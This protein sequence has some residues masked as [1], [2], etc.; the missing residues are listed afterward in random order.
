MLIPHY[1]SAT[2]FRLTGELHSQIEEA[3]V[4]KPRSFVKTQLAPFGSNTVLT[5]E[6]SWPIL[7]SL[8]ESIENQMATIIR[9]HSAFWWLHLYRRIGVY[10]S[11]KHE[12][13]TDSATLAI[14][15]TTVELA[16]FKYSNLDRSDDMQMSN[17]LRSKDVLGGL[18]R[19]T[20]KMAK[21][22]HREYLGLN[23]RRIKSSNQWVIRDFCQADFINMYRLEGLAYQ[24]WRI[25]AKLRAIG[26]GDV[27]QITE[28]GDIQTKPCPD[29]D[30][31]L[32]NYDNRLE[33]VG[34]DHSNAG[35][36]FFTDLESAHLI[37]VAYY[38]VDKESLRPPFSEYIE[39]IDESPMN[40]QVGL[41]DGLS[42]LESHRFLEGDF[43]RTFGYRLSSLVR[44]IAISHLNPFLM[45]VPGG[46]D[47]LRLMGVNV[48]QRAYTVDRG[49]FYEIK[50][51]K[52]KISEQGS[53]KIFLGSHEQ[54]V[55]DIDG[56]MERLVLSKKNQKKICLWSW[57]P[58][59]L[60]IPFREHLITD[61]TSATQILNSAFFG[62]TFSTKQEGKG[63]IFEDNVRFLLNGN[64]FDLLPQRVLDAGKAGRREADALV[65]RGDMLFALECRAKFRP[66]DFEI[67]RPKTISSRQKHLN[68]K[69][70][71]ASSLADFVRANP[72]G[73][74]YDFTWANRVE[75][76]VVSPY[77]EWVW[78]R[79]KEYW[80]TSSIPRIVSGKEVVDII[81]QAGTAD[82][83]QY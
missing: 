46:E 68:E 28:T 60:H 14:V 18:Y 49:S 63:P 62:I 5:P 41:I 25:G 44:Y 31:L 53:T 72:K 4:E 12:G 82:S 76:F 69:L 83:P 2:F 19:D 37:P 77:V 35:M 70:E 74:N 54:F 24:Y 80:Y 81:R 61:Y 17:T 42:Y 36:G 45:S 3:L 13:K 58:R 71:Q 29:L 64:N 30:F 11:K 7:H 16:L 23:W 43:Y 78:S 48:L 59:Y 9:A 22:D 50:K 38:N 20:A 33:S 1:H 65:R 15:R 26:K 52:L 47:A 57:G 73:R 39:T 67:G 10:L 55:K 8:L 40:F 79:E 34:F 51:F 75:H 21:P 56:I 27:I 6:N 66:L 32:T